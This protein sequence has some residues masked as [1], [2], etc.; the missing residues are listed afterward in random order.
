MDKIQNT[1]W[2][3]LTL[4]PF[5]PIYHW[6]KLLKSVVTYFIR[7]KNFCLISV[8]ISFKKRLRVALCNNYFVFDGAIYQQ[9]DGV[10]MGSPLGPSLA[11]P[12]LAHYKHIWLYDC[13]DEFK[14]VYYKRYV[15]DTFV[16]F[17]SPHH[18]EK[19]NEY[20]NTKHANIKF[21]NENLI[22]IY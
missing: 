15:D 8:K 16:L 2:P 21:T 18:L 6:R 19:S 11:N 3:V 13:S 20:L 5:S 10:A 17:R 1:L 4:I 22:I 14:S 9:V 12:F 7:I